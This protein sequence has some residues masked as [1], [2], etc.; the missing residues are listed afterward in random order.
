MGRSIITNFDMPFAHRVPEE[1]TTE[2]INTA[3]ADA[4]MRTEP[5]KEAADHYFNENDF[6]AYRSRIAELLG[7]DAAE[8][9][10][11]REEMGVDT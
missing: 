5:Y 9:V 2:A 10:G 1:P 3:L 11:R 6:M 4:A 8:S 7:V